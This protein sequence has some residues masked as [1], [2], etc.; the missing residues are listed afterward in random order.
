M[1]LTLL[2]REL[3]G[4]KR[5]TAVVAACLA[6]AIALVIV[7]SSLATGV[8]QAQATAL[9]GVAG[10]GTDLTVTGAPSEPGADGGGGPRFE[11]GA[12]EGATSDGT[13][14]ISQ[15]R[16]ATDRMR[17][18]LEAEALTTV[19]GVAG[20][21]AATGVLS[22]TNTSFSGEMPDPAALAGDGAGQPGA[23]GGAPG[24]GAGGP[25][26]SGGSA[27]DIDSF[28]VLGVDPAATAVGPLTG[29]ALDDGRLLTD[30]DNSSDAATVALL[31][32]T[33]AAS[34]DLAVGDTLDVGG[35]SAEVVGLVSS[36][37]D[38]ASTAANVYL[39]LAAAQQLAG[40]GE[41][42]STI[43]VAADSASD[44]D[45][46]QD[47]IATALP[48]ATVSSQAELAAQV[49]GSLASASSLISSLGTWLS[50]IVLA[51]AL[52]IA[53]LL[54]N[55]GVQRRTR[56]FGTLKAIG[57]SNGRVVRQIAGESLV[58]SVLGGIVG[59]AL[60][61]AAVW[62]VNLVGVT[63]P[64]GA[65]AAG[66]AAGAGGG[67]GM[68]DGAGQGGPGGGFGGPGQAV[69]EVADIVLQ[70]PITPWIV[71]AALAL[72]I[73]GGVLAGAFGAWRAV[74]LSPVEALRT[75]A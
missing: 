70:A 31:D 75:I 48:D 25:G 16:L 33:Y 13:T 7:V 66:S 15:S 3:S 74:R 65:S 58:Q 19:Q 45:A 47:Q 4:R 50:L 14:S 30:A 39:A 55:A 36:T 10:V 71:G 68:P 12:D 69:A 1:Y 27:F 73:L 38:E 61:V 23:A 5:Q 49:S 62:I 6:I 53:V 29:V 32:A 44:A 63:L 28:T 46:V 43:Y 51:V 20:V 54:T 59:I 11:F 56:E 64:G 2:R 40:S 26:G 24:S 18:T 21:S 72:S 57:W 37:T 35:S 52:A 8:R 60:G 22:L 67:A 9:E 42:V 41:V 17:G 34:A